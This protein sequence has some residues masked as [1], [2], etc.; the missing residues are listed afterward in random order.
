MLQPLEDRS[1][2]AFVASLVADVN[3][4]TADS[5]PILLEVLNGSAL[6][7]NIDATHGRELWASDGTAAGTV[8][9]KD[10]NPGSASGLYGG[11]RW[12]TVLDGIGYFPAND[13]IN[14]F[15]LWRTDGTEA[16]TYMVK[17]INPGLANSDPRGLELV[18]ER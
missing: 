2:P 12:F 8:M 15:E 11:D 6:M 1:V 13:G 5:A 9:V 18:P 7:M 17:D 10:I 4:G 14:G 3:P 16:G